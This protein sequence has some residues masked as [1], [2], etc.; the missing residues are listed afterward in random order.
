MSRKLGRRSSSAFRFWHWGP[1][2]L[3]WEASWNRLH[4]RDRFESTLRHAQNSR[5]HLQDPQTIK[6]LIVDILLWSLPFLQ[7]E[8]RI[9][10]PSYEQFKEQGS[11]TYSVY[12]LTSRYWLFYF[13]EVKGRVNKKKK[14][15]RTQGENSALRKSI[16]RQA[17]SGPRNKQEIWNSRMSLLI[18]Q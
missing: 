4:N 15:R 13:H 18:P 17:L 16:P 3:Y 5:V 6:T 2:K 1:L 7:W 10:G 14:Q 11:C 8:E 9:L 12:K